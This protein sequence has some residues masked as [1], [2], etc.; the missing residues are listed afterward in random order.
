MSLTKDELN[1]VK[2]YSSKQSTKR[3]T[4]FPQLKG[5]LYLYNIDLLLYIRIGLAFGKL[6][7]QF[8]ERDTFLKLTLQLN[9]RSIIVSE[10]IVANDLETVVFVCRYLAI[11]VPNIK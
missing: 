6:Q 10:K 7:Y 1:Y 11:H 9:S 2:H 5:M 8:E 4:E 3:S